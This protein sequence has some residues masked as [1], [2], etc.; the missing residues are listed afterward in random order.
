MATKQ[1]TRQGRSASAVQSRDVG[2]VRA[3]ERA[4][5]LLQLLAS[6][7]EGLTLSELAELAGLPV[8]T[9]HRLLVTLEARRFVRFE[10]SYGLWQI[11][12]A[13]F[14]VGS[15]FAR[16]RDIVALARP[17]MRRLV[18]D[19]GETANLAIADEGEM[20]YL[21]Q[22][23]SR[24]MMRAI[25]RPGGRVKMHCSALGKAILS[26][27]PDAEVSRILQ[28]HGLAA[29]TPKTL[30]TPRG[31]RAELA[32]TRAR[33]FAIDDEEYAVGLRCIAAPLFDEHA[34][35]FAALSISGPSLRIHDGRIAALG[36]LLRTTAAQLTA[37]Y[38]GSTPAA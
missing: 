10:P 32:R 28:G 24:E 9:V 1:R 30:T 8:A 5:S 20:V 36:E 3:V 26:F 13:A 22:I 38:G 21:A 17:L 15:A 31:L 29:M 2:T 14:T 34:R 16:S 6:A 11:G 7:G 19:T 25:A 4:L 35:P 23:E 12:V 27:L 37:A 33:G 18:A